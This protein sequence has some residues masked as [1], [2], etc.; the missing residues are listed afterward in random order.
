MSESSSESSTSLSLI[1]VD[2]YYTVIHVDDTVSRAHHLEVLTEMTQEIVQFLDEKQ[3]DTFIPGEQTPSEFSSSSSST[4]S[5]IQTSSSSSSTFVLVTSSSSSS[6]STASSSKS[7]I[8]FSSFTSS[9]SSLS[10]LSS[11]SFEFSSFSQSSSSSID[12]D[13]MFFTNF[14]NANS[15]VNHN[16]LL[17]NG[18]NNAWDACANATLMI[19]AG[20]AGYVEWEVENITN[21][22]IG[23][24]T[25]YEDNH[26]ITTLDYYFGQIGSMVTVVE[27]GTAVFFQVGAVTAGDKMRIFVSND[28]RIKYQVN[29]V[30]VYNSNK[31]NTF[32]PLSF[33]TFIYTPGAQL[34]SGK[35]SGNLT[36]LIVDDE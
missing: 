11:S 2:R 25:R 23:S 20:S 32:Y 4:S 5:E 28:G 35:I 26:T 16:N 12:P 9:S 30:T 6:H 8:E 24:L 21:N 33:K 22:I 14:V 10:S 31:V 17:K 29:G 13:N 15:E 3:F 7:S 19:N 36:E 18:N 34:L 27:Q 1:Q